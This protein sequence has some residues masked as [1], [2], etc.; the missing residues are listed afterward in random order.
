MRSPAAEAEKRALRRF[1]ATSSL[2]LAALIAV[3]WHPARAGAGERIVIFASE[4]LGDEWIETHFNTIPEGRPSYNQCEISLSEVLGGMGFTGAGGEFT[5]T[6]REQARKLRTVFRRYRDMSTMANDTAVKASGIVDDE[7]H[8]VVLCTA[9]VGT[10]RRW[11]R[12]GGANSCAEVRCK[13][14]STLDLSRVATHSIKR[15]AEGLGTAGAGVEAI[16]AACSEAG[17]GLGE[18]IIGLKEKGI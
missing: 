6:Q 5:G 13:A 17:A 15:C 4:K 14:V 10:K 8:A 2:F 11:R 18:K 16:R 12:K 9:E 3:A 1:L 7:A